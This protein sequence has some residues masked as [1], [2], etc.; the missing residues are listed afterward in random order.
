MYGSS[1]NTGSCQIIISTRFGKMSNISDYAN[2]VLC[3]SREMLGAL[4]SQE[5][6]TQWSLLL[7]IQSKQRNS[8]RHFANMHFN[9]LRFGFLFK[10]VLYVVVAISSRF[11]LL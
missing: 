3:L 5:K 1:S 9:R 2:H 11:W 7:A 6:N 4:T 10:N 8:T